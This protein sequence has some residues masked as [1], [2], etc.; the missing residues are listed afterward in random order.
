MRH[1]VMLGLA[2][3]LLAGCG[4]SGGMTTS[5]KPSA[6]NSESALRAAERPQ[7]LD[8][9]MKKGEVRWLYGTRFTG[10]IESII[11]LGATNPTVTLSAVA[12]SQAQGTLTFQTHEDLTGLKSGDVIEVFVNY[13]YIETKTRAI[14]K[15]S[16]PYWITMV[17]R[18]SSGS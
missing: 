15:L 16:S 7:W 10:R 8:D 2:S 18:V 1:L 14:V 11:P 17:K 6:S 13:P 9:R 5:L 12:D 4:A 3:M